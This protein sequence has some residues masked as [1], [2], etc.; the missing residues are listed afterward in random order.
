[1]AMVIQ[2]QTEVLP[3]YRLVR[4]LGRGGAGEV[5]ECQAPG[6]I[7]K[8]VKIVAYDEKTM[9]QR[10]VAGLQLM[11]SIRHP[12]LLAIER[13]DVIG[14]QLVIVMELAE[15]SLADRFFEYRKQGLPGIPREEL[16]RYMVEAAEVLDHICQS[17]HVQHLDIKPENLFLSGGH[18]KVGDFGLVQPRYTNIASSALAIS[19]PYAP[20]ELFDGRVDASADQFSLAVTYQELATGSRPFT[21]ESVRGLM[22]QHLAGKSD[23][24]PL[25]PCDRPII[26]RAL[27]R[28][29]SLRHNSCTDLV[30]ALKRAGAFGTPT[31]EPPKLI[32]R[33][34]VRKL[35]RTTAVQK[36]KPTGAK[37][38]AIKKSQLEQEKPVA[39]GHEAIAPTA[40]YEPAPTPLVA[41]PTRPLTPGSAPPTTLPNAAPGPVSAPMSNPAG[42][43][44]PHEASRTTPTSMAVTPP[45]P[46][47][48]KA[49]AAS[50]APLD[51]ALPSSE[52][53]VVPYSAAKPLFT[54][55][56]AYADRVH[57]SFVAF[58]PL[59]I[60]AHK[61]RGFIDSMDAE[62]LNCEEE[63]TV[64][65]FR[66]RGFLGLRFGVG[67]FLE[68]ETG[69]FSDDA[70][71]RVVAATVWSSAKSL[72]SAELGR[73]GRLL[74]Q[75]LRSFLMA[76][77]GEPAPKFSAQ[78][79][80]EILA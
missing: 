66:N 6:G 25:A 28:A 55:T 79:R 1:M 14:A 57:A 44:R 11:R 61:L 42:F 52:Q 24:T 37:T 59:E 16:L 22:L 34:P 2:P 51:A 69:H 67:L 76:T 75:V 15:C 43:S 21:A 3:G 13:Y 23:L 31:A 77:S 78:V 32:G 50:S 40:P 30:Q 45:T 68:L 72:S 26:A 63:R 18:V 36:Q 74:I 12:Y 80:A 20:P 46:L 62:I 5:W 49:P 29:P 9:S 54:A 65:L 19:P 48:P 27:S 10:E 38:V 60:F 47:A 35:S 58:L 7:A 71:F 64:L 17:H 56:G 33:L 39:R 73:R 4:F 41:A 8:A 70:G 53:T